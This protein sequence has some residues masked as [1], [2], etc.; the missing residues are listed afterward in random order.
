MK[1]ELVATSKAPAA[2]GPYSQ[3]AIAGSFVFCSGQIAMDPVSGE[4]VGE[5]TAGQTRQVL[6]NL[7]A[8]L[9]AAGSALDRVVKTTVFLADMHDFAEMN[10]VYEEFFAGHRPARAAVEVARLPRDV[11]VEIEA[12]ATI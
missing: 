10:A 5:D 4:I 6:V 3:A 11:R 8:V 12:I 9:T 2:L 7:S 1:I